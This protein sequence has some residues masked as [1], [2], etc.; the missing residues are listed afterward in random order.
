[1]T[2]DVI[3]C[4]TTKAG[5]RGW[6]ESYL[7]TKG[8][9]EWQLHDENRWLDSGELAE[10]LTFPAPSR[11]ATIRLKINVKG[12]ELVEVAGAIGHSP[13]FPE[14][15]PGDEAELAAVLDAIRARW[16]APKG[17]GGIPLSER[18]PEDEGNERRKVKLREYL[19]WILVRGKSQ[20]FAEQMIGE[21]RTN[22]QRWR[23]D[24]PEIEE[25]VLRQKGERRRK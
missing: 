16:A 20:R 9:K 8:Y 23:G 17:R 4:K 7:A 11:Y 3:L 2:E 25:D 6:L 5:L 24:F 12:P 22:L 13:D 18:E 1:M 15:D 21:S 10:F 14:T 19:V